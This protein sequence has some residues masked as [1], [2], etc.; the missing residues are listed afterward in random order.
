MV[1]N[2]SLA[3]LTFSALKGFCGALFAS[4]KQNHT[5]DLDASRNWV[6]WFPL[7]V[8]DATYPLVSSARALEAQESLLREETI[9]SCFISKVS[10]SLTPFYGRSEG[11]Y[12]PREWLV[13]PLLLSHS[14]WTFLNFGLRYPQRRGEGELWFS[15]VLRLRTRDSDQYYDVAV[16]TIFFYD[17]FLTLADE[18]SNTISIS[19]RQVY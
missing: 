16:A 14:W 13:S 3:R 8:R 18:V 19:L 11:D 4:A 17:Y 2:T 5:S 1:K 15:S 9:L 7:S 12:R 6:R 10:L